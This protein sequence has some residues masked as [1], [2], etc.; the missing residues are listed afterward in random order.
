MG[1]PFASNRHTSQLTYRVRHFK[2]TPPHW[3]NGYLPGRQRVRSI[4]YADTNHS[5]RC[6]DALDIHFVDEYQP[7]AFNTPIPVLHHWKAAVKQALD[8]DNGIGT[9]EPLPQGT[10]VEWCSRMITVLKHENSPRRT[11]KLQELND[12]T[13]RETHHTP[14]P[15]QQVS[16]VSSGVVYTRRSDDITID[17]PSKAKC[18]DDTLSWDSTTEAAFWHTLD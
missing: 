1:V 6:Q 14:S 12:A 5:L 17:V 10:P 15:N 4:R 2:T 18:I 7:K 11:M 13:K 9:I 8:R 3:R 16:I